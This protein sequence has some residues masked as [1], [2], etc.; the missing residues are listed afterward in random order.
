MPF[1]C[2]GD[3]S[4]DSDEYLTGFGPVELGPLP[5]GQEIY[6]PHP[7]PPPPPV[8]VSREDG[9]ARRPQGAIFP[10]NMLGLANDSDDEGPSNVTLPGPSRT[11]SRRPSRTGTSP[12]FETRD[13]RPSQAGASTA[14][15]SRGPSPQRR[16]T[17][18]NTSPFRS[19]V[20][21]D[22]NASSLGPLRT[23]IPARSR[24]P[25]PESL[26]QMDAPP[27][28]RTPGSFSWRNA[29]PSQ[30]I[31]PG[32]IGPPDEG[33]SQ[34]ATSG[35]SSLIDSSC[36]IDPSCLIDLSPPMSRTPSVLGSREGRDGGARNIRPPS[37][38][39]PGPPLSRNPSTR[40]LRDPPP[41]SR[42]PGSV[43]VGQAVSRTASVPA[44]RDCPLHGTTPASSL[45][46]NPRLP[47]HAPVVSSTPVPGIN[48]MRTFGQR[49]LQREAQRS[50]DAGSHQGNRP[51]SGT[52][53]SRTL[54]DI[55][56]QFPLPPGH[57]E[58]NDSSSNSYITDSST[59]EIG[60]AKWLPSP[61]STPR[62][63]AGPVIQEK[64]SGN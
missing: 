29:G 26:H 64:P 34:M 62:N 18:R 57:L 60:H 40:T 4:S 48:D 23:R 15:S 27:R 16:L 3:D 38:K 32:L 21:D 43:N 51:A 25:S 31:N 54:G 30:P 49:R 45:S 6:H 52:R 2:C 59:S 53:R 46:R 20:S 47:V 55:L 12:L 24:A 63:D 11:T 41:R 33:R 50:E 37:F 13:A 1:C 17:S 56:A 9:P 5:P 19:Q 39:D 7:P 44:L 14:V 10:P 8:A 22:P 42:N 35:H 28:A 36:I 61:T 58:F